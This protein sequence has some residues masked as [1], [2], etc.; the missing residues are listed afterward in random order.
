LLPALLLS[1]A[2][3]PLDAALKTAENSTVIVNANEIKSDENRLDIETAF[4]QPIC[5][6]YVAYARGTE[7]IVVTARHCAE[8]H[9]RE[10]GYV[11]L[12][13]TSVTFFDGDVGKVEAATPDR[14]DDILVLKVKS[15][16]PHPYVYSTNAVSRTEPLF[17]FGR[18]NGHAWS[19][20]IAT[21]MQGTVYADSVE[22]KFERTYLLSCPACG[23]GI[24]GGPVF[25]SHGRV[26]GI[27]DAGN[28][29]YTLIIP[30]ALIAAFLKS[31]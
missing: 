5:S 16:R 14:S 26:V 15:M 6:G 20:A 4:N 2:L 12:H 13:P 21:I 23:P 3:S 18:P 8:P 9:P 29:Q 25:N 24:S 17:A 31:L 7:E 11:D 28:D 19:Y 22:D 10:N 1:L 27:V 30:A